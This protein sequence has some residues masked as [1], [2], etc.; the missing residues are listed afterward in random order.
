MLGFK[1]SQATVSRYMPLAHMH[2]GVNHGGTFLRNQLPALPAPVRGADGEEDTRSPIFFE[3]NGL[4]RIYCTEDRVKPNSFTRTL[5]WAAPRPSLS[6][7]HKT[8]QT[9]K[10]TQQPVIPAVPQGEIRRPKHARRPGT[11][12]RTLIR[13]PFLLGRGFEKGQ[14]M[15]VAHR[16]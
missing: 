9:D 1:V 2:D 15:M 8:R 3:L 7:R 14:V 16:S 11:I 6:P 4:P 12:S 5:E 13:C 10:R